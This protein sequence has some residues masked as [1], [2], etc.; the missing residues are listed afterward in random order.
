MIIREDYC[1]TLEQREARHRGEWAKGKVNSE[2][3][4]ETALTHMSKSCRIVNIYVHRSLS[5]SCAVALIERWMCM[6]TRPNSA[7]TTSRSSKQACEII[8]EPL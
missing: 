3:S 4:L 2:C 7:E 5:T 1:G 8:S 6:C